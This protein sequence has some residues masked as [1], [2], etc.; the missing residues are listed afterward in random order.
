MNELKL[1]INE[2]IN[3]FGITRRMSEYENKATFQGHYLGMAWQILNPLIQIGTFY[4]IFGVGVNAGR[5]VDGVPFFAWMLIGMSCWLFMNSSITGCSKSIYTQIGMV[6]KMKFP[7]SILPAINITSNLPTFFVMIGVSIIVLF[8]FG[9][10]PTI[11]WLQAFYYFFCMIVFLYFLGLLNATLSTLVRDYHMI[12]QSILRI[13][14]FL[15]GPVWNIEERNFPEF[16][17]H[18]LELNP[19]HFI[20]NGFR[21]ALLSRQFV[22]EQWNLNFFFWTLVMFI[23]IIGC[24]LHLKFRAKFVD[25]L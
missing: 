24:H 21:D 14:F 15:S 23:A 11:Y 16:F 8:L 25:F 6:S 18:I 4:L 22:F 12:L 13:L 3:N 20:I 17:I 2:Q 9:I 19:I 1:I 10:Y 5:D 7:I